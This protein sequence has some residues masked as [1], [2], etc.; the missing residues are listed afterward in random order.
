[1]FNYPFLKRLP[2]AWLQLRHQRIRLIVA[3]AG[4]IFAVVIVFM[5]LG[6]RDA[7]FDS[8]VRLHQGLEGDIF[9]ISPRSTS[10]IAMEDFSQRRLSQA[11]ALEGVDYVAPIYLD[12]GQWRNPVTRNYWRNIY[13]IGFDIRHPVLSYPGVQENLESLKEP[14][15]VLFD[16][17]SRYEFGPVVSMFEKQG[18]VTT[19]VGAGSGNRRVEVTG[20]FKLGT[21]FGSDGNLVT[22]HLNF[23]RI[24]DNRKEGLIDIGVIKLKADAD[25]EKALRE[26]HQILPEDVRI[27][28]KAELVEFEKDYWQSSTAI[29][30]VFNLGV[31]LG[32]IVGVVVVY[33][34]LYSNVSE[35]LA[36]YA[37]L[38]AMGYRHQY[39]LAMVLQQAL[40]IG[41]LGYIPGFLI[42]VIQYEF[43]KQATL[44]PVAMTFGRA[45]F[46]LVATVS[47][48]FI[49]GATAVGKLKAA[50]PA[51]IF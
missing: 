33:Q 10:L 9:L 43:I 7:L 14:D 41:L 22:S 13:I 45:I 21:S 20:L 39:L 36:Q 50:D 27:L 38:K 51:E 3:L 49:S 17:D 11:M 42:S 16:R 26:L 1:M 23:L 46:V 44:L 29:G 5:Q 32:I 30:F 19:E 48:C 2:S 40:I 25:L 6:I 4:V 37:T 15:K 8:A 18:T 24:V 47:M 31:A 28:S 35:H 12:F 34:I